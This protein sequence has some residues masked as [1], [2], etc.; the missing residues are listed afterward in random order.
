MNLDESLSHFIKFLLCLIWVF[1]HTIGNHHRKKTTFLLFFALISYISSSYSIN[2]RLY[3]QTYSPGWLVIKN[4]IKNIT[5]NHNNCGRGICELVQQSGLPLQFLEKQQ[6]QG[7]PLPTIPLL[8]LLCLRFLP[9]RSIH[10]SVPSV[11]STRLFFLARLSFE[12]CKE[13]GFF[14]LRCKSQE[15]TGCPKKRTNKTNKNG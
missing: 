15:Y 8:H 14:I 5:K 6:C 2:L 3:L 12:N 7:P 4:S 10:P 9:F 11:H 13:S 1:Q